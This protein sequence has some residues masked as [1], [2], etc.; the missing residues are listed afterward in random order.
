[1]ILQ[2]KLLQIIA[3]IFRKSVLAKKKDE[4]NLIIFCLL[5][6]C[7]TQPTTRCAHACAKREIWLP[8]N[9]LSTLLSV[10]CKLNS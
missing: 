7:R 5:A 1:M 10:L 2:I 6:R 3:N 9:H 4:Q 8:V